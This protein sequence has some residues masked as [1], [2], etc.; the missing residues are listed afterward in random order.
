MIYK[1]GDVVRIKDIDWYNANHDKPWG[2]MSDGIPFMDDM[3]DVLCGK[4][5]TIKDVGNGYYYING[6]GYMINDSMIDHSMDQGTLPY[7]T[8]VMVSNDG[9]SFYLNYISLGKACHDMANP[10]VSEEWKYVIPY[11]L[12]DPLDFGKSIKNSL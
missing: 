5:V 12:F 3:A 8:P 1:V 11:D 10:D 2:F 4:N 7:G 9:I 6:H